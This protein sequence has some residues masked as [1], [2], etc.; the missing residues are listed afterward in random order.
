MIISI[1]IAVLSLTVVAFFLALCIFFISKKFHVEEDPLIGVITKLLPGVNCG[2]C[3]Y[4]GCANLAE[5]LVNTR[6]P[7]KV[8]PVGGSDLAQQIGQALGIKMIETKPV[9]CTVLCQGTSDRA[10][11]TADYRGI[12]DCRAATLIYNGPKQ[13]P[14]ACVGLGTCI[15]ACKY[16]ALKITNGLIDVIEERCVG[17]GACVQVCPKNV[18]V[19]HEKK[20]NRYLVACRSKDKGAVT[21]KYC[22]IGCIGCMKCKKVCEF[23]AITVE[24]FCAE[25]DQEKCTSCGKCIEVCPTKCIVLKNDIAQI[26]N[27]KEA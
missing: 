19:M 20:E 12:Q 7:S 13:C 6:D 21:K 23:D 14:Y 10:K 24:N 17:C 9:V 16:G 15:S 8:C 22:S 18:L 3:G 25:I 11:P 4:P 5:A 27:A 2:A 26:S 1:L